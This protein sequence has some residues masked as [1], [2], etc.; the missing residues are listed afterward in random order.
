MRHTRSVVVLMFVRSS[1]IFDISVRMELYR[2]SRNLP[3]FKP[4]VRLDMQ[5][6]V[7]VTQLS[8][9]NTLLQRLGLRRC[10]VLVRATDIKSVAISGP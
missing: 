10:A 5:R 7:L 3:Q 9:C 8:W 6:I 1:R 4:L 2:K